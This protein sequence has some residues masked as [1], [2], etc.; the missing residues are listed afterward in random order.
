M[1]LTTNAK[2]KKLYPGWEVR[3]IQ[4][5]PRDT[6]GPWNLCPMASTTRS[7]PN[8]EE[9]RIVLD[10][11]YHV[12]V[13]GQC[14]TE[15]EHYGV[16]DGDKHD[17]FFLRDEQILVLKPKNGIKIGEG[18]ARACIFTSG[19]GRYEK[20][21]RARNIKTAILMLDRQR[22]LEEINFEL[23]CFEPKCS[24][25]GVQPAVR[26]NCFSDVPWESKAWGEVPQ[27]HPNITFYDY[28]KLF[29]RMVRYMDGKFP[30]N[31]H[32]CFSH[33]NRW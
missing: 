16:A 2:L 28:T 9:C 7:K 20:T 21:K 19:Y 22:G 18:C 24:E 12:S 33:N 17:L 32:L 5:S 23:D 8:T 13:I 14:P 26:P 4:L 15:W 11:G 10:R 30:P 6:A 3:G 31:Y 1:F 29:K 27:K 25:L